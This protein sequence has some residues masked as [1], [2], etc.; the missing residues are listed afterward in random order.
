MHSIRVKITAIT[1]VAILTSVLSVFAACY[2][3]I[4]AQNDRRSVEMM[5][6]IAQDTGKSLEKYIE[7]IEQSVEMAANM[8]SDTLDS[9]MLVEGGVAGVHARETAQTPEQAAKLDAYL[10]R[11]CAQIREAFASVASH[12][13]GVVTYYYCISPDISQSVHGFFY[14]KVGKT[15]FDE[16]E[17][18]DARELDPD[19]IAH[20]TWYYTPI[21]RGRPSWVGPYSAHFLDEMWTYSYLVPI[22]KAGAFIGVLGMDIPFDTLVTQISSIRVFKS[23]YACLVDS[24]GRIFYHPDLPAGSLP[25]AFGVSDLA[26]KLKQENSGDGLIRYTAD[27]EAR[28]LSFTTLSNGMKLVIIAPVSEI[29]ASW[30]RLIRIILPVTAAIIA[31]FAILSL[32]T[33]KLIVRPLQRLTAASQRL[34]DGDY[35]VALDYKGR[36]EVGKLTGAFMRMR[37]QQKE[38]FDELNRQIYTDHLTGLPNMRYFFKLAQTER[39]AI[40]EAG[41]HPALLYFNLVGLKQYNRQFGFEE[42]DRLIRTFASVLSRH[43]SAHSLG[44]I[45]QDRF[46]VL[47]DEENPEDEIHAVF[48]DFE[49][50]GDNRTP[51]VSVGVYPDKWEDV[52]ISVACDRAK[53]ACDQRRQS[54]VSDIRYFDDDM[55]EQGEIFRYIISHLDQALSEGWIKVYYQAIIRAANGKVC[56]EE[57]LSRWIDPERGF[58]S[59][60]DF[61][62]ALEDAKLIYKLDL[63]VVEQVL[64]KMKRQAEAGLYVVPTSVNLSRMDFDSCDIVEEI[65]RRVDEAGIERSMLTI[66]ITESVVG[67]DFDFMKRQVERF[68]KLGFQVWMDDFGSGYSS[69]DVLQNIHFDLLKFDMRFMQQFDNGD[70]GRI[71]LTELTKMAIGLGVETICEGA[72]RAEQVEFLREIGCTKIQGFYY[73]RPISFDQMLSQYN[74][75]HD[76]GFENP[77]ESSYYAALGRINLYDMAVLSGEDDDSLNRYFD[78]LPMSIVEVNGTHIKYNRCNKSYR[79]FLKRAFGVDFSTA[80]MDYAE[81]PEGPGLAFM[82]AVMRCSIDG[83]RAILDERIN[84]ETTVHALIRRVAV[85]PV[86]GTAAIAMA[87][88]A[89]MKESDS[90]GT[91]YAHIAKALSADYVYLYYVD[92]D[93]EKFIEYSPDA[94][95]E[96]LAVERRGENFFAASS[97][98]ALE[99]IYKDDRDDF[100]RAFQ[101]ENIEKALEEQGTFTL[102][103]RLL[104]SG[105]PVYVNMKVVRMPGDRSHI[106]IGV[107]NVDAQMRQKEAMARLQAERITYSRIN[108]LAKGYICIYTVDPATGHYTEY[109]ATDSYAGLGLAKEGEDFFAQALRESA[110]VIVPEDVEKFRTMFTREKV[111]EEIARSGLFSLQYRMI[112]DGE[113]KYVG[114]KAALVE[115]Q[116]GPQLIIGVNNIDAQVRREQDYERRLIAARGGA[117]LDTLTGVKN[118]MAYDNMS[119]ALARQIEG[120]QQVKYAI[121]LCR[122]VGLSQVNETRGRDAGDQLIRQACAVICNTFKHSPVFRVAGDEFAA[123]AQGHDYESIDELLVSLEETNRANRETGGVV[124]ACGMARY[125]G[126]ASVSSVFERAE[127]LCRS[128]E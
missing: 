105:E 18:L 127:T 85:N 67:S 128:E 122:V 7:S 110:R 77:Q 115:E 107:S 83:N 37:D 109:S 20:T 76:M 66:E 53:Y 64:E 61:I 19:D 112:L 69:L 14:S 48:R 44:R 15:G 82:G 5:N 101:R 114:T 39:R 93:T 36:D 63:Y 25:D 33:M 108:A 73:G 52:D 106:I 96:D 123:I 87:V 99:Y 102:T 16:Q 55:L 116:D 60:A 10:A 68:Q 57:A 1:I 24:D 34:A 98:D 29:N 54:F 118:R 3:T 74:A 81:M 119:E 43:Y 126:A 94:V 91:N 31:L 30:T 11:H 47:T 22:Y 75:G 42:G 88:L 4:K 78:T 26:E 27:G 8:A 58:L 90:A 32:F 12:T 79:D 51:P 13:Q 72:E 80:D 92:I 124:I 56:D 117:N 70:A 38:S 6:L 2:S 17:P 89:V 121:V 41:R 100:L 111:M 46:V 21:Q 120:G 86:T 84:D 97:A 40:R 71:I 9:V 125:D 95:R 59:P 104:I 50:S 45:S 113:A 49:S 65:R 103:Y 23:G 35:D 28:Q 62:P